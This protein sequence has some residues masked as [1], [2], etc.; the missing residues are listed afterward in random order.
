MKTLFATAALVV[1]TTLAAAPVSATPSHAQMARE[2][3]TVVADDAAYI[4]ACGSAESVWS[5]WSMRSTGVNTTIRQLAASRLK[6]RDGRGMSRS[7]GLLC[8][9]RQLSASSRRKAIKAAWR[10]SGASPIIAAGRGSLLVQPAPLV[11]RAMNHYTAA[12]RITGVVAIDGD[13]IRL[14]APGKDLRLRI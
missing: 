6:W 1:A 8:R 10:P 4:M 2:V 3:C 11:R 13:T 9:S 12:L 7:A 5:V 14:D